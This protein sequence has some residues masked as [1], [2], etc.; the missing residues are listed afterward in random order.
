[1]IHVLAA[2]L[3]LAH[4]DT[5]Q[6]SFPQAI[7]HART[8]NPSFMRERLQ[9]ENSEVALN[10]SWADRYLPEI[11]LEFMAPE[12]VA[13]VGAA[14][15]DEQGRQLFTFTERQT[16]STSLQLSQPLITGGTLRI[17]GNLDASKY[18]TAD[19]DERYS[20]Q[21]FLG[22]ELS[23]QVFGINNSIRQ[24]RLAQESFARAEAEF[25]NEERNLA[26]NVMEAYYGLVQALKQAEID[27]VLFVR[28]S[29]RNAAAGSGGAERISEVDSLKFE[30]EAARSAFNRT[31]SFQSLAR[32]RS[33]LNEVLALPPNTI[34]VPDS[35]IRVQRMVPDIAAGL[36]AA[37]LK[38]QDLRLAQLAV[39]N[40]RAGLRDAHRTSPVTLFIRSRIGFDGN[41]DDFPDNS[42]PRIALEN[43]LATQLRSNRIS[44]GIDIPLF[45]RFDERNAVARSSNDLRSAEISLADQLRR[46]ENE[47]RNAAQRVQNA[48]TGLEL[49]ERQFSITRRTL[50]IQTPRFNRGEITSV[51][52]LIDQASARQAEIGLLSAQVELLTA[53]EEWRRATGEK[54]GLTSGVPPA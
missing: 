40:R 8:T 29:L 11:S 41:S 38:R 44:M 24:W 25:A 23:Q 26:R 37:R 16:V 35:A 22:F 48:T 21:S 30:L 20:S 2:V 34:V 9:F 46:L 52:F 3:A 15:F 39:E 1:M 18:P 32:A 17:T 7:D 31:R 45:D 27:S 28:D 19:R 6:L 47:V 12:Y 33:R 53:I 43:A 51:E 5:V 10:G 42:R 54:S 50:E 4:Q 13:A 49:A 14:G 36:A